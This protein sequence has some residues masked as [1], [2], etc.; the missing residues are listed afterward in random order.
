MKSFIVFVEDD[1]IQEA[2]DQA[3]ENGSGESLTDEE[4]LE[5]ACT[6]NIK[7]YKGG[8]HDRGKSRKTI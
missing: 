2:K 3:L 6:I 1:E 4:A 7:V 5:S 8:S